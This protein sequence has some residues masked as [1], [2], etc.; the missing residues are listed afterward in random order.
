VFIYEGLLER[1]DLREPIEARVLLL[2][3]AVV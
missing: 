3:Q 1:Y 2:S